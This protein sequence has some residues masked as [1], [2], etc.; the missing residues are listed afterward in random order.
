[1]AILHRFA[2]VVEEASID[3]AYFDLSFAGSRRPLK[4]VGKL[5]GKSKRRSIFPVQSTS[6]SAAETAPAMHYPALPDR[7]VHPATARDGH[8]PQDKTGEGLPWSKVSLP[9]H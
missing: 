8:I 5:S 3:E 7:D 9:Y 2:K 1:M 4:F 6:R